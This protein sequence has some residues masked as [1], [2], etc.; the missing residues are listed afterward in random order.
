MNDEG[1]LYG[2]IGYHG[3]STTYLKK[4]LNKPSDSQF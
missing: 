4:T 2:I 3:K 1:N